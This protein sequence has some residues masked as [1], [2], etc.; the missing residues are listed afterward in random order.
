ME[1]KKSGESKFFRNF[2]YEA[3][4]SDPFS[5]QES[6]AGDLDGDLSSSSGQSDSFDSVSDL[7]SKSHPRDSF[8]RFSPMKQ[9]K[10]SRV[11]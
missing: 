9:E 6:L 5:D 10:G 1:G 8:L 7:C 2:I 11:K 3:S 4:D